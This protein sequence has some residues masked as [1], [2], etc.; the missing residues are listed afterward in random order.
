MMRFLL[1][2]LLLIPFSGEGQLKR[3][4]IAGSYTAPPPPTEPREYYISEDGTGDGTIA[5]TPAPLSILLSAQLISGDEIFFN[6][7]DVFHINELDIHNINNVSVNAF[8]SGAD[9]ILDGASTKTGW[10]NNG[11]G[12]YYTSQAEEPK[13]VWINGVVAKLAESPW[14]QIT[15]ASSTTVRRI[16]AATLAGLSTIV[17]AKIIFKEFDFRATEL[18][19]ATGENDGTGDVTFTPALATGYAAAGMALKFLNQAQFLTDE[20]DWYY[21]DAAERLYI[22]TVSSPTDVKIATE[23]DGIH[24]SNVN[25]I[26]MSDIDFRNYYRNAINVFSANDMTLDN[27]NFDECRG[28]AVRIQ[29]TSSNVTISDSNF[30]DL[31]LRGIEHAG[32]ST[33][34]IL[35]NTFD[36]IGIQGNIGFPY[37]QN[38]TGGTAVT[39]MVNSTGLT[40]SVSTNV[41]V[42][43]CVMTD[44]GYQGI[45]HW[46]S[47]FT[48]KRNR[49]DNFDLK[50]ND[51]GAI[52]T[53]YRTVLS[54][55]TQNGLIEDNIISNGVGN[56]EGTDHTAFAE[57][58]YIDNG[59]NNITIDNNTVYNI[60]DAGILANWDTKITT[61]TNNNV[62]GCDIYQV[63]L[64]QDTD[65]ADSPV[66]PN[67]NGN[68]VTGNI[69][70]TRSNTSRCVNAASL[71]GITTYNPFSSGGN[72]DNNRYVN[73]YG[74]NINSYNASATVT[75]YTLATWR[76]KMGLD[77]ASSERTNYITFSSDANADEEVKVEI[78][79]T[80]A[81]VNFNVPA[82]YSDYAGNAFSNP[83]SI[84]PY[85]SLVYFKNTAFP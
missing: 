52:H 73:P 82:G 28:T 35:R 43:Q 16:S 37:D 27:L 19:T 80:D 79:Y 57:G 12:T 1:I 18:H 49:I 39:I 68:I 13:A 69:L 48:F 24:I 84:A 15:A 31:G 74:V 36:D 61:I 54:S 42:D 29:G 34:N 10:V 11:D 63:W 53:I 30:E 25:V 56:A 17:G 33:L 59:C 9:P 71:N 26:S 44:L 66:W 2:F 62:L 21:D 5:G 72:S 78:N 67:N 50:W 32:V 55:A 40:S 58:I 76:T 75:N 22:K 77:A 46:G 4:F 14:Y 81:S 60:S 38:H 41:T 65:V 8:G 3:F 6:R 83:V 85:S 7:G 20:G 51:G 64:R 23:N 70:A 45:H 47:N